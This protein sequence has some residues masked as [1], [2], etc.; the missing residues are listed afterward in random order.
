MHWMSGV[1]AHRQAKKLLSGLCNLGAY[2]KVIQGPVNY[3]LTLLCRVN[4]GQFENCNL[5][6]IIDRPL[7]ILV[8]LVRFIGCCKQYYYFLG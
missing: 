8:M 3:W 7:M 4:V 5:L 1:I 6:D 2:K